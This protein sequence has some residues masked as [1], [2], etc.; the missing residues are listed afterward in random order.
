MELDGA[1]DGEAANL[2]NELA[3]ECTDFCWQ[4]YSKLAELVGILQVLQCGMRIRPDHDSD[5]PVVRSQ[6]CGILFDLVEDDEERISEGHHL[7]FVGITDSR[8]N[9]R[10]RFGE[11]VALSWQPLAVADTNASDGVFG[12]GAICPDIES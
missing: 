10:M 4:S 1:L 5:R 2:G 11:P 8:D 3:D 6:G 7:A 12:W 9:K